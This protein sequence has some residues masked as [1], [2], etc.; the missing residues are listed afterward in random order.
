[1]L[2]PFERDKT[3]YYTIYKILWRCKAS[4]LINTSH[5][6][7]YIKKIFFLKKK[8]KGEAPYLG[9][10]INIQWDFLIIRLVK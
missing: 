10:V 9:K 8:R 5:I 7:I 3:T 1:M 2:I 6:I 4:P